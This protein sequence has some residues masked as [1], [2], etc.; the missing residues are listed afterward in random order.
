MLV[1]LERI[2]LTAQELSRPIPSFSNRQFVVAKFKKSVSEE[3][4]IREMFWYRQELLKRV[5]ATWNEVSKA[6]CISLRSY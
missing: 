4:S 3:T 5:Q 6:T 2:N 1:R